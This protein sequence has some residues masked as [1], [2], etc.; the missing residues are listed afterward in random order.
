MIVEVMGGTDE[1]PEVRVVDVDDL[2]RL[3]LAVGD[4]E[5]CVTRPRPEPVIMPPTRARIRDHDRRRRDMTC[6]NART[7]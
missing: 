6:T 5:P 1:V 7:Q 2:T 4:V 3:H